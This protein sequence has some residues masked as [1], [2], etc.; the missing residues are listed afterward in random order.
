M[1]TFGAYDD[2][3]LATHAGEI[4]TKL[5]ERGSVQL[6]VCLLGHLDHQREAKITSATVSVRAWC[7]ALAAPWETI[8]ADFVTVAGTEEKDA[9]AAL[10]LLTCEKGVKDAPKASVETPPKE[11]YVLKVTATEDDWISYEVEALKYGEFRS[12]FVSDLELEVT[13]YAEEGLVVSFRN[14]AGTYLSVLPG[15]CARIDDIELNYYRVFLFKTPEEVSEKIRELLHANIA[16]K[17]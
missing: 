13:E 1:L 7:M 5:R 3:D 9:A 15:E 17:G 4:F 16:R 12:A 11:V 8:R 10:F 14:G 6:L 2:R